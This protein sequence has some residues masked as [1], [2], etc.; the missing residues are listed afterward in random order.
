MRR[1]C[2]E[3]S[4]ELKEKWNSEVER[5]CKEEANHS[6]AHLLHNEKNIALYG[7]VN[8][9]AT[10]SAKRVAKMKGKNAKHYV[11]S[12]AA[13]EHI[14]T[15]LACWCLLNQHILQN[16]PKE[17]KDLWIRHSLEEIGH[18]K[19]AID[20]YRAMDGS[21]EWR[22]KWMKIM[23]VLTL[24]DMIRQTF[25]NIWRMGGFFKLSTWINGYRILFG[26]GGVIR[27]SYPYLKAYGKKD[28]HINHH[29]ELI[30][31]CLQQVK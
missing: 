11:A 17:T 16:A 25:N 27:W 5:F 1:G 18:R 14:T 31:H 8:N 19:V 7:F 15:I 10:R 20:L 30:N 13:V 23:Y 29:E 6:K 3:L 12:T 22:I 2:A 26:K 28:Y 4:E 9:W 24:T 21:E